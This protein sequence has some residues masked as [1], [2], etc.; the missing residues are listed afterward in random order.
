L[1]N[2]W[3]AV[4]KDSYFGNQGTKVTGETVLAVAITGQNHNL[5]LPF[6]RFLNC[7][8]R[9]LTIPSSPLTG[10]HL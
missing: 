4:P 2:V 9:L 5:F 8:D 3:G 7:R 10:E 1:W 6:S